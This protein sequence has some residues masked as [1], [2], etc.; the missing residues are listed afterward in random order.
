MILP[1]KVGSALWKVLGGLR[2]KASTKTL[3]LVVKL[4]SHVYMTCHPQLRL[5]SN[6]N[7]ISCLYATLYSH[8]NA[9]CQ[10]WTSKC[11][12]FSKAPPEDDHRLCLLT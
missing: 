12:T 5:M 1:T 10:S 8:F 6:P 11:A 9:S 3:I 7:C 4:E 2:S